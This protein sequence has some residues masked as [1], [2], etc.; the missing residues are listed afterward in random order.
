MCGNPIMAPT[1]SLMRDYL[2]SRCVNTHEPQEAF[3][4]DGCAAAL[5]TDTHFIK[6]VTQMSRTS[7]MRLASARLRA[8]RAFKISIQWTDAGIM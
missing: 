2:R 8:S 5:T 7:N 4:D 3:N 1:E 6:G